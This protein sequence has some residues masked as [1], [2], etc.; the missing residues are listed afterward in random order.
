M[1]GLESF[2][3]GQSGFFCVCAQDT[4]R[5]LSLYT[6]T[7]TKRLVDT[8]PNHRHRVFIVLFF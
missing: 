8:R 5:V 2:W 4:D 1:A 3:V 7:K 6:F